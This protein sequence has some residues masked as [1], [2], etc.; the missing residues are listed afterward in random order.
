MI[1]VTD[2]K[3]YEVTSDTTLTGTV[4]AA[5]GDIVVALVT[6]RDTYT[7]PSGWTLVFGGD[8]FDTTVGNGQR[9]YFASKRISEAGT[10]SFTA[11]QATAQRLYLNLI[12]L[13]GVARV[14]YNAA[15]TKT[16][17]ISTGN[18]A[19]PNKT[20]GEALLWGVSCAYAGTN[21]LWSSTPSDI[22]I[23]QLPSTTN[24]R[25]ALLF[26]SGG[27][28]VSRTL[29]YG[30]VN[31][32]PCYICALV[33]SQDH[34]A[35]GDAILSCALS[36]VSAYG[37]SGITWTADEPEGTSVLMYAQITD[38]A[39]EPSS[40]DWLACQNGDE[41]P[42]FDIGESYEGKTL[43]IKAALATTDTAL[44][45]S[46]SSVFIRVT[47]ETDAAVLLLTLAD[48]G[49]IN[50]AEGDLTVAYDKTLGNL[51][52]AGG[53]VESFSQAFTPASL[54]K[55]PNPNDAEHITA[56]VAA[57]GALMRVYYIDSSEAEHISAAISA[58]GTLISVSDI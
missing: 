15:Y 57:S 53:A 44:T 24:A 32:Y 54:E 29:T 22:T 58:T 16:A 21:N 26:D 52:G 2:S 41:L 7:V 28:A 9:V 55:K 25:S 23:H 3:S 51:A 31:G 33:L 13:H 35:S 50:N 17:N 1:T 45:P 56:A 27:G 14:S 11:V 12:A 6:V 10:V 38:E 40:E 34:Y 48:N 46:L 8:I 30:T 36:A 37:S 43:W 39:G 5:A 42:C 19:L 18:L 47:D 4:T 20:A 49:R